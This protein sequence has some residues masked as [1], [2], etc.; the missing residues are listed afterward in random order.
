MNFFII[1]INF[2]IKFLKKK[3]V[4]SQRKEVADAALAQCSRLGSVT[5]RALVLFTSADPALFRLQVSEFSISSSI[6]GTLFHSPFRL[7]GKFFSFIAYRFS[8]TCFSFSLLSQILPQH[9]H[10]LN[11]IFHSYFCRYCSWIR[12]VAII[13]IKYVTFQSVFFSSFN[14]IPIHYLPLCLHPAAVVILIHFQLYLM[15][16]LKS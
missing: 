7:H 16:T 9:L 11:L 3:N 4:N 6:I 14:Q 5:L 12:W 2:F 8:F 10:P 13:S 1:L 15:S